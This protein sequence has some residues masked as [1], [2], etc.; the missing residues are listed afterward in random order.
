MRDLT[1]N[2]KALTLILS[3]LVTAGGILVRR[4]QH[5]VIVVRVGRLLIQFNEPEQ[6]KRKPNVRSKKR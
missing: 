3:A 6:P 4:L 2:L 1:P 5:K